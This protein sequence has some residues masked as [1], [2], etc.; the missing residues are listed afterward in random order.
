MGKFVQKFEFQ[1]F[2]SNKENCL[3]F[4]FVQTKILSSME[5]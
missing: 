4:F 3:K 5:G 1:N 2:S